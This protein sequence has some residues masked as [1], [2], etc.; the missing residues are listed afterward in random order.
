MSLLSSGH[1]I[2]SP[3]TRSSTSARNRRSQ[4]ATSA[5]A[6][7][8]SLAR[9]RP[10]P[11]DQDGGH[12]PP[13]A[14]E[15]HQLRRHDVLA[16]RRGVRRGRRPAIVVTF[17]PYALADWDGYAD[18]AIGR[19]RRVRHRGRLRPP[20]QRSGPGDP[21]GRRRD[22]GRRQHVP[23]A[24][25]P[26]RPRRDRRA[27]RRVREGATRYMGAS[28]G[29]NVACPTIRTTNDMPICQPPSFAALGLVPFQINLHYVDADPASTFMGETRE[30]RIAEFLEEND[31][32][33]LAHVRGLV[34]AGQRRSG[35]VVTGRPVCSERAGGRGRSIGRPRRLGLA[36]N[37]T[38]RLRRR[39]T[40]P[41]REDAVMTGHDRR[42]LLRATSAPATAR[43][44][45]VSSVTPRSTRSSSVIDSTKAGLDA[46]AFLDERAERHPDLRRPRRR[47]RRLR[48]RPRLLHLR[49]GAARAAC[50]RRPSAASCSTR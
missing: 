14:L 1:A 7:R 8:Q 26:L 41:S 5:A 48:P 22:D 17:V 35:A 6:K 36:S 13:A 21:R 37:I 3:R 9:D 44:P 18:R 11:A 45:T 30:E 40:A 39:Q 12:G 33:V 46:G 16:R 27:R 28:A 15:L 47:H 2:P 34:A 24:R 23:A 32:P 49:R 43:P 19:A 20:V 42:R 4:P 29:T 10:W 25:L 31:C 50:S 38:P